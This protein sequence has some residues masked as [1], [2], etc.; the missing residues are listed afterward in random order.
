GRRHLVQLITIQN[1]KELEFDTASIP[2]LHRGGG[3]G[4]GTLLYWR[5]RLNRRGEARLLIAPPLASAEDDGDDSRLVGH[6]K[7]EQK[8]KNALE[9]A[10]VLYVACTRAV[11]RL[12][13]LFAEPARSPAS[14][15][16]L[17]SLWPAFEQGFAASGAELREHPGNPGS[18]DD[19]EQDGDA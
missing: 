2:G 4:E 19:A 9:D 10:R 13:L 16:L 17:A 7:H 8:R 11:R 18:A 1:S 15:S 12:H 5:E 6:L 14:G 3:K